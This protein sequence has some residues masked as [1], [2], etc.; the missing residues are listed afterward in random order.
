MVVVF[1]NILSF[2]IELKNQVLPCPYVRSYSGERGHQLLQENWI[3]V[4]AR[5]V[6]TFVRVSISDTPSVKHWQN[7]G[8]VLDTSKEKNS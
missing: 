1:N 3:I 7:L 5:P 8:N 4:L 2:M 6:E